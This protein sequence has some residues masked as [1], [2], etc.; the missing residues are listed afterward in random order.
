MYE[1]LHFT[2]IG[3]RSAGFRDCGKIKESE[4]GDNL[5]DF[6]IQLVVCKSCGLSQVK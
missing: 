3:T 5:D 2:H 6:E 1:P 4:S